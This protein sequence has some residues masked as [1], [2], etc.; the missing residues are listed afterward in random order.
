MADRD[1][2]VDLLVLGGGAAGL[3]GAM[4]AAGVGARTVL[5]ERDRTGGDCLWTGCV[6]SKTLLAAAA[7]ARTRAMLTGQDPDFS[8]VRTM[9]RDAIAAIEPAD[10]PQTLEA[11]GVRFIRGAARFEAPGV[12]TVDGRTIRF[13]QALIATGAA[14]HVPEVPGLA[15]PSV[16]TSETVWDLPAIPA[17]L[18]VIGGGPLGCELGQAFARLGSE[19]T[20]IIRSTILPRED[21][22][23]AALVK[24]SLEADGIRVL[25]H[26]RVERIS[27]TKPGSRLELRD[28]TVL[29][30]DT[31]LLAAGRTARTAGLG[32]E[33]LDISTDAHGQIITD[34]RMRTTNPSVW[35]AGD[36]TAHPRFT[37][38]AGVHASIAARNAVLGLNLKISP[39]VPRVTYTSPELAAVGATHPPGTRAMV[40]TIHHT[41]VDRAVTDN[42]TDGFTRLIADQRGHILGATIVGPRAGESVAEVVLAIEHRLK[43]S[44]IA[45]ATHPYPTYSDGVWNAAIAD[46]RARLR[47]PATAAVIKILLLLRRWRADLDTRLIRR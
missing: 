20:L 17:R 12:A 16:V 13:R 19:V 18:A 6:P 27:P 46:V 22:D 43:T 31:V 5:V 47:A 36:V 21:R 28:G 34:P 7:T 40:R 23:A 45:A 30:A 44:D 15:G 11:A 8:L 4:T 3:V 14:P 39:V 35:A 33:H 9:I 1:G 41:H 26:T 25:E 24:T 38:V 2:I 37:H 42:T 10:S 32:L 29:T